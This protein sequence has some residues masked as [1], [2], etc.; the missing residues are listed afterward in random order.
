MEKEVDPAEEGR[1][2]LD[3][4]ARNSNAYQKCRH[5]MLISHAFPGLESWTDWKT[6]GWNYK[7]VRSIIRFTGN[8][9]SLFGVTSE[10]GAFC[11]WGF[12]DSSQNDPNHVRL[13]LGCLQKPFC[14]PRFRRNHLPVVFDKHF[15]R[16]GNFYP[17]HCSFSSSLLFCHITPASRLCSTKVAEEEFERVEINDGRACWVDSLWRASL[18]QKS[19]F[20]RTF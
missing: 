20:N 5:F 17:V 14:G 4:A 19:P 16:I 15:H 18:F 8:E 13:G 12:L 6:P 7:L 3:W 1:K 9:A 11:G 10:Y 2:E